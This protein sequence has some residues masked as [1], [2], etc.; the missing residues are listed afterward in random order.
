ML[1]AVASLQYP[2]SPTVVGVQWSSVTLAGYGRRVL[3][4]YSRLGG[5]SS[6]RKVEF[7]FHLFWIHLM[8][9]FC[10][11]LGGEAGSFGVDFT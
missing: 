9:W 7:V 1:R 3:A 8:L 10:F 11:L 4:V 6:S 2:E 5:Q